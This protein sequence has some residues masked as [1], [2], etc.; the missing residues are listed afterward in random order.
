MNP[1]DTS[2]QWIWGR[3]LRPRISDC[4][5]GALAIAGWF[6]SWKFLW[7]NGW[8]MD[9]N[10]GVP[11][12]LRKPLKPLDHFVGN[13]QVLP[14]Q[15][16]RKCWVLNRPKPWLSWCKLTKTDSREYLAV[17]VGQGDG[18]IKAPLVTWQY[19]LSSKSFVKTCAFSILLLWMASRID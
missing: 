6:I 14:S 10:W 11:L 9:D 8:S 19:F 4:S 13:L 5:H 12:W 18:C 3:L 2:Q 15:W 1:T 16:H 7:K 17:R